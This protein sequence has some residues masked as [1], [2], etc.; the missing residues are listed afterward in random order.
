M[1]GFLRKKVPEEA[2]VIWQHA[3][4][5]VWTKWEHEVKM[6]G[7][8]T[9]EFLLPL[10]EPEDA[11]AIYRLLIRK[12]PRPTRWKTAAQLALEGTWA[13]VYD[14]LNASDNP[15]D[16]FRKRMYYR[17]AMYAAAAMYSKLIDPGESRQCVRT[18][19]EVLSLGIW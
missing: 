18:R 19:D 17:Q 8:D 16:N 2:G 1:F 14:L 3:G 9:G 7:Q 11:E 15:W 6:H 10:V 13:S 12:Q 5:E 4:L